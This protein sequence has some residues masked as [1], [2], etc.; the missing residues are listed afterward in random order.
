MASYWT[1]D[2]TSG[3]G[4]WVPHGGIGYLGNVIFKVTADTIETL[5]D[6][7]WTAKAKYATHD[8]HLRTQMLE[9]TGLEA[10]EITFDIYLSAFLGVDPMTEYT[11]L[12]G[13]MDNA[14]AIPF[15][16]GKH[17]YGHYRWVITAL[18]LK[19]KT[20]DGKGN[21]TEATVSVTLKEF[22]TR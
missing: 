16:L 17:R 5:Q 6:F 3:F 21:W 9:F 20:T 13:Y 18:P 7:Q 14:T 8:R 11:K 4:V 10:Q 22:N 15:K 12:R 2:I 19:G 1:Y